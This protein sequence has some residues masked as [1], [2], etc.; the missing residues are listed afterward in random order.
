MSTIEFRNSYLLPGKIQYP[1]IALISSESVYEF[2][3]RI[4]LKLETGNVYCIDSDLTC[5]GGAISWFFTGLD[6]HLEE[7]EE[8]IPEQVFWDGEGMT[9][10]QIKELGFA[11]GLTGFEGTFSIFKPIGKLLERVV[12]TSSRVNS[13]DELQELFMLSESIFKM[14]I[15]SYCSE[16]WIA[17]IA[18]GY[19]LGKRIFSFPW[20]RPGF[21]T[22]YKDLWIKKVL[23]PLVKADCLVI[24]PTVFREE[25]ADLFTKVVFFMESEGHICDEPVE[26]RELPDSYL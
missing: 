23:T 26:I 4:S 21:I 19:A 7:F 6:N 15:E 25:M 24:I 3:H 14:P 1:E 2:S 10:K 13:I 12:K 16:Y 11:V 8:C 9:H 18:M 22:Q 17:T 20:M 5:G